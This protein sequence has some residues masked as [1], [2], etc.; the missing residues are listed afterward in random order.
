MLKNTMW[1][2]I[3]IVLALVIIAFLKF[4]HYKKTFHIFILIIVL[5]LIY[6]SMNAMIQTGEMDFSSPR[7]SINSMGIYFSWLG[8]TGIEL[9]SI[10]QGTIRTVGN[11]ILTNQTEQK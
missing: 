6:V 9:F 8:Q 1:W 10:G 4:E 7:S 5:V 3:L 11:V 2:I